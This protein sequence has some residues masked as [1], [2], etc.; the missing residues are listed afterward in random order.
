MA[1]LASRPSLPVELPFAYRVAS[2]AAREAIACFN[3]S[4]L[5]FGISTWTVASSTL[6]AWMS[7][8]ILLSDSWKPSRTHHGDALFLGGLESVVD[9]DLA[10]HPWQAMENRYARQRLVDRFRKQSASLGGNL[11]IVVEDGRSDTPK[12]RFPRRALSSLKPILVRRFAMRTLSA[13]RGIDE[14]RDP[15]SQGR[16]RR[17]KVVCQQVGEMLGRGTN[18]DVTSRIVG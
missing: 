11:R 2:A 18:A 8:R 17:S 1:A 16:R 10:L 7:W 6:R 12:L 4:A 14:S 15:L 5:D 9:S 13:T 3:S